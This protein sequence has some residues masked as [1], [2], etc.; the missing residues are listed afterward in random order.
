MTSLARQN[1]AVAL[2]VL[3][4]TWLRELLAALP[5]KWRKRFGAEGWRI[6]QPEAPAIGWTG[7]ETSPVAI[8]VPPQDVLV[9]R[10]E[11]PL[12]SRFRLAGL[13]RFEAPRHIPLPPD[14]VR[15]DF[16]VAR[17]DLAASRMLV[18]LAIIRVETIEAAR[19]ETMKAGLEPEA[20]YLAT[21]YGPWF[22]RRFLA[23]HWREIWLTRRRQR[24]YLRVL[25]AS[26]L[27][28]T[29]VLGAQ[30]WAER[31]ARD[32]QAAMLAARKEAAGIEPLRKQLTVLNGKLAFLAAAR[33]R[34]SAAV[35]A[36]EV[37]RLLPD[38][39]WLQ[40]L[41]I[42]DRTVRLVGT[43]RDASDLLRVF[44]VSPLFSDVRFEAPLIPS[45]GTGGV[46]F[47]IVLN[48][49]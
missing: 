42:Q 39:A 5:P 34:P 12:V 9:R 13:M 21:E 46:R 44:S 26:L 16:R 47:D 27:I 37:A 6:V 22:A 7:H 38:D 28:L 8:S 18:E 41:D 17:R 29:A 45:P 24:H 4:E 3:G 10:I 25:V 48:L 40:E 35:V 30:H 2:E 14:Q 31:L 33:H 32:R 1:P 15:I 36:E 43:A 49:R 19:S 20:V 23:R 11:L